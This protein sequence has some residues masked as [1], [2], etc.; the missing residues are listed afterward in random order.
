[1]KNFT[2]N[3]NSDRRQLSRSVKVLRSVHMPDFMAR[4]RAIYGDKV[5]GVTGSE[6]IAQD[7]SGDCSKARVIRGV[8]KNRQT[9]TRR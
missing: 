6:L 4:L 7:R 1:M 3:T 2:S 9:A 8:G 5:L